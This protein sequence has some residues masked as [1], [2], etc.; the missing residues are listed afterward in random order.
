MIEKNKIIEYLKK[1]EINN[2]NIIN[3]M[4]NYP[5]YYTEKVGDSVIIK[6]TS[7]RNWIYI[8]C[9]S[10]EEL[11]IIRSKLDYNDKQSFAIIEE[12]M[13]PILIKDSKIK[14]KLST[15]RLILSNS[16]SIHKP[17][18]SASKLT[19]NDAEFIY[20]NSDYKDFISIEYISERITNGVSSCIRYG[21][22]PIAWAIT[23]DDGAIGFLHVLPEYRNRGHAKD[24]II[25]LI[26][27]VRDEN[28][29][30]FAHIEEKN[31]RSMRLA[32]GLGFKKDKVV[33]WFE[34]E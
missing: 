28:K 23:Q 34:I 2:I 14:W 27:K 16:T 18:H 7:D 20:E 26:K 31:E 19:I 4:E 10:K 1:D 33:N 11:T 22:K 21:D 29:I 24:V 13:S 32:L 15:M 9:K 8:S 3:F 25:D 12:W 30:P 6:G 5:I 17:K